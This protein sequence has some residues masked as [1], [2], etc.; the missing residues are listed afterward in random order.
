MSE[1]N[2]EQVRVAIVTEV[3]RIEEDTLY[4]A[5]GH[6]EA[7]RLWSSAHFYIG[8][9]T[10]LIAAI[11]GVTALKSQP[12]VAAVL[13]MTVAASSA[14]LTF[15]NPRERGAT[16]LRAGNLYKALSN[17][18]RIF[19]EVRCRQIDADAVLAKEL[20][21]LNSRRSK[22]NE[23]SPPISRRAFKRGRQG[24]QDGEATYDADARRIVGKS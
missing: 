13:A 14:L 16:H 20:D 9:P 12:I 23:E 11:A 17:D 18:A 5:K 2:R 24:I 8:I 7:A 21:N 6:L 15:L 10:T 4:S 22:L 19:R 1:P 3:L